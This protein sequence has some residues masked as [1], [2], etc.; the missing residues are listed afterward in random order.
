MPNYV[1]NQTANALN[2]HGKP[3]KNSN[4][5]ILGVSYKKNIDDYN[6]LVVYLEKLYDILPDDRYKKNFK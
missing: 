1:V 4:I 6:T 5:L 3:L 2:N